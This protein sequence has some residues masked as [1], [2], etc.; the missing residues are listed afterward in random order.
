M[1]YHYVSGDESIV[2]VDG[3]GVITCA[4]VTSSR[5]QKSGTTT[6]S[7]LDGNENVVATAEVTVMGTYTDTD[8]S[9]KVRISV[10]KVAAN[11]DYT[12][13]VKADGSVYYWGTPAD[14]I[15]APT[16]VPKRLAGLDNIVDLAAG[17][18]YGI[19]VDTEGKVFVWG[20]NAS[21][22]LGLYTSEEVFKKTI[23]ISRDSSNNDVTATIN[24]TVYSFENVSSVTAL[25][26]LFDGKKIVAVAAGADHTL[27]LDETGHVWAMGGNTYGQLGQGST[28]SYYG[29]RM[30]LT[31]ISAGDDPIYLDQIIE[32]SAG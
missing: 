15:H 28:D 2:K 13:A 14:G 21:G 9:E 8:G 29:P 5:R 22:Q 31:G 20:A 18:G 27:L 23:V 19:A 7:I 10:P 16:N 11:N 4:A 26:G 3:N 25:E 24:E 6:I 32:I 12:Y 1:A 17:D 30:V